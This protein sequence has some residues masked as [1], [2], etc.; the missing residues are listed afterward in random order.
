MAAM[1]YKIQNFFDITKSERKSS[2]SGDKALTSFTDNWFNFSE[3]NL[4][5][6]H[7]SIDIF[8]DL[9]NNNKNLYSNFLYNGSW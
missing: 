9:K 3:H 1:F 7:N 6:I 2:K 4:V 8:I 5:R